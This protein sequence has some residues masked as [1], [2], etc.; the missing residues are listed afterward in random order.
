MGETCDYSGGEYREF[1]EEQFLPGLLLQ[2]QLGNVRG[3]EQLPPVV[4]LLVDRFSQAG[5]TGYHDDNTWHR[6]SRLSADDWEWCDRDGVRQAGSQI[7]FL[8]RAEQF[9]PQL[10]LRTEE[11]YTLVINMR[12]ASASTLIR[13][14]TS[15]D[16]MPCPRSSGETVACR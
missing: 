6:H 1:E 8:L 15:T 16:G 10:R 12:D 5:S 14:S 11:R 3:I 2:V 4:V 9:P 7:A 13:K